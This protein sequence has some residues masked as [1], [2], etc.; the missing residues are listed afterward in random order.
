MAWRMAAVSP[1]I[2]PPWAKTE[3]VVKSAIMS[4]AQIMILLLMFIV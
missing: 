4:V 2:P 3:E 1:R